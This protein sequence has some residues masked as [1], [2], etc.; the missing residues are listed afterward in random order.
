MK[1]NRFILLILFSFYLNNNLKC[2]INLEVSFPLVQFQISNINEARFGLNKYYVNKF[3][4]PNLLFTKQFGKFNLGFQSYYNFKEIEVPK[5]STGRIASLQIKS[6]VIQFGRSIEVGRKF[7]IDL[8]IGASYY[9][10]WVGYYI[11]F[12][13]EPLKYGLCYEFQ[14]ITPLVYSNLKFNFSNRFHLLISNSYRLSLKSF[15]K[16][17]RCFFSH[18]HD[19]LNLLVS[20]LMI[21]Y[22][23]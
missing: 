20:Q 12:I 19:R 8:G 18:G 22:K 10:S 1:I 15:D 23:F 3:K 6:Y 2:Q 13:E 7:G 17:E 16:P 9:D 11:E 14:K 4:L 21:G 5:G